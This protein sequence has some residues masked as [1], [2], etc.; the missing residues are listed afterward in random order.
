MKNLKY[1]ILSLMG[2]V[3]LA[4]CSDDDNEIRPAGNPVMEVKSQFQNVHFGDNLPFTVTVN[5]DIALSTL[6]AQLYFGEEVVSTTTIRTKSNGEYSG[7]ISVPFYKG[8]PD[9][10]ATLEFVLLNTTMKN[11]KQTFDLPVTRAD[12]PYLI[13]ITENASYPMLPTGTPYE[14]AVTE[15][16][17]STD[18]PAYIKTPVVDEKGTELVFGW[19]SGAITEGVSNYIPFVSPQG[20]AYSVVFNT[21]TYEA[22]P[23]FEILLN[24]QKMSMVDKENYQIDLELTQGE[25]LTIEGISGIENWWIDADFIEEKSEGVYNFVPITGKYRIAAN[26]TKQYFKVE[27]L[28]GNSLAT[29]QE[30]GT[31]AIWVIGEG[32]GKPDIATSQVGW[33]P[34]NALCMSPIADK[35]YQLTVVGGETVNTDAINFK[36]FHQKDWG[37]ELTHEFMTTN[38]NLIFIGDGENGLDPGN[39]GL[40]PDVTLEEG[41]TYVFTVDVTAGIDKAVL[42]VVKK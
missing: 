37:G 27:V 20:G 35:I 17:P 11:S 16:F 6:T 5:D 4:S 2:F 30:D 38:S 24:G 12:Y 3:L 36:F 41:A 13:L 40:L 7:T 18:L 1:W 34:G 42:T 29:L 31:G 33:T 22:A 19:E 23:F 39:L 32:V 14:Y 28:S 25:E 15:A 21:K 26:L 10:T 8:T 9:G